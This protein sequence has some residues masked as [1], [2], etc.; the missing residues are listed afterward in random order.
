MPIKKLMFKPG[1]NREIT[2]FTNDMG[3]YD[4]DKVRF[5]QGLPEKIGGWTRISSSTYLGVCRSLF[6]WNNNGGTEYVGVGTNLKFY[7]EF[8]GAY[9]DVTPIRTT[10]AAGDVTFSATNGSSTLTVTDTAHGALTN[11]FVTFSGALSLGGAVSAEVLNQEHQISNVIDEDIYEIELSTTATTLDTGNGGA[12]VVGEY[13]VN[14]GPEV[15]VPLTGWGAGAWGEGAWGESATSTERLRLWFQDNFGEDLLLNH[16]GGALYY[17]DVSS[18]T[19]TRAVR[20]D[21]LPGASDVPV[22][23]NISL[24]SDVFRFAFCFGANNIGESTVDSMLVRWSD[25]EDVTNWT[26]SA[27]NQAGSLRLS[28]GSEIVG[29]IQARQEVLVWTDSALFSLQYL[30]APAVWGAQLIGAN[31]TI[32]G[33]KAIAYANGVAYWMGKDNLYQYDG[34]VT[35][36][37]SDVLKYVF[38]D[39]NRAQFRQVFAGTVEE[40][41]EIWWFYCSADSTIIDR[42]IIFDYLENDWSYGTLARTAWADSSLLDYPI[43]A[44]YSHNIVEHENGLDDNETATTLPINAYVQ[45][46][47][48]SIEDGDRAMFI[49]R[50]LPDIGFQGSTADNPSVDMSFFPRP[51]SGGAYKNPASV[52][53]ASEAT[54]TRS[55]TVPVE[56]F[57]E[58]LNIRVRGRNMAIRIESNDLGVTWQLGIPRVDMRP[59]G[60]RG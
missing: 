24:V 33:P 48:F 42:Y 43:A 18:G 58:Q 51:N 8:G 46:G 6:V 12:S 47:S 21:S 31:S 1:I 41:N 15:N 52:G 13:Q 56:V 22:V 20:V 5:R 23:V 40:Y 55:T 44:T 45:S 36:L 60:R 2:R 10:T 53:A 27:T 49:W 19:S 9:F 25:I 14:T 37:K 7:I 39:I 32:A 35:P 11:D 57:T 28:R 29:A 30:G 34:R 17:W 38:N 4:C 16:Y 26:P 59:D 3:W 54:V 50:V